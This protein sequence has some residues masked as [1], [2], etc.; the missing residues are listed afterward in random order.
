MRRIILSLAFLIGSSV[1]ALAQQPSVGMV[2]ISPGVYEPLGPSNALSV[3]TVQVAVSVI[4]TT[5]ATAAAMPAVIGKTNYLCGFS[6]DA[7]AT[8]LAS[9][10]MVLT[11]V[12][13]GT[14]T[15]GL[16]IPAISSSGQAFHQ[17]PF[18]PCIPASAANTAITITAGA[19]GAGGTESVN[20]W[21]FVR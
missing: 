14:M 21:G 9:G 17:R 13:G 3:N 20:I 2:Q 6:V 16:N 12:L 15:W 19:A 10:T 4:G 7:G 8:A 11:G 18:F 5:A 1:A